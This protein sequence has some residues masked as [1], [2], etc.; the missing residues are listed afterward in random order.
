LAVEQAKQISEKYAERGT[1]VYPDHWWQWVLGM[2]GLP[3]RMG[4]SEGSIR[5]FPKATVWTA[6]GFTVV[7]LI[8][9][10]EPTGTLTRSLALIPSEIL[11]MGGLNLLT[12]F[13]VHADLGHLL[14]NLYVMLLVSS[15]CEEDLGGRRFGILLVGAILGADLLDLL[16]LSAPEMPRVGA[17]GGIFGLVFYYAF[18][19]P[20]A[21]FGF[22]IPIRFIFVRL[23][24]WAFFIVWLLLVSTGPQV[25]HLAHLGG[26]LTGIVFWMRWGRQEGGGPT[27]Q[28][29]GSSEGGDSRPTT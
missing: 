6:L 1:F 4:S 2:L 20:G 11:R 26:A 15:R 16:F 25:N 29:G 3:V 9:L 24:A 28:A 23:P 13:L 21:R 27:A 10:G 12:N 7:S 22:M 8:C 19:F 5:T 17:S 14:G 18:R